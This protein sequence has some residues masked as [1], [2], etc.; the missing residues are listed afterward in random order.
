MISAEKL[1]SLKMMTPPD[2][3]GWQRFKDLQKKLGKALTDGG[4]PE[5]VAFVGLTK[6]EIAFLQVAMDFLEPRA[7][8]D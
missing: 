5:D 6:W 1:T 7:G 4:T 8:E 3:D 2:E